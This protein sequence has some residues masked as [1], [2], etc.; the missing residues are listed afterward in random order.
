MS[1]CADEATREIGRLVLTCV[2]VITGGNS[3]SGERR[4]EVVPFIVLGDA[5][6][7]QAQ[8]CSTAIQGNRMADNK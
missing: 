7:E 8:A 1:E 3:N 6:G 5:S 2:R 4:A